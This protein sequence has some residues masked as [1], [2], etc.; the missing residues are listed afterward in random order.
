MFIGLKMQSKGN[1][2]PAHPE[3]REQ[4]AQPRPAVAQ[5]VIV[6]AHTPAFVAEVNPAAMPAKA[7]VVQASSLAPGFPQASAPP[8]GFQ[9]G[10]PY[11]TGIATATAT[12][13]TA[14]PIVPQGP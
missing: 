14:Q 8:A 7:I 3:F 5:A 10:V 1:T 6:Q 13:V 11:Q 9:T 12:A 4:P 2:Q